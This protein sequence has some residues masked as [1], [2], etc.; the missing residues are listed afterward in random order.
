MVKENI[1]IAAQIDHNVLRIEDKIDAIGVQLR[2]LCRKRDEDEH[3]GDE[4]K[5]EDKTNVTVRETA[6][7][8]PARVTM[9]TKS[10]RLRRRPSKA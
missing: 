2:D 3:S 4:D 9:M 6:T 1:D 5:G 7:A 10:K 8:W